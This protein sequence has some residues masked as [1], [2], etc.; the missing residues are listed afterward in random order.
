MS[1]RSFNVGENTISREMYRRNGNDSMG[2]LV[3]VEP[4]AN[5]Y[6]NLP[7][8]AQGV[9]AQFRLS[10][11]SPVWTWTHPEY[12]PQNKVRLEFTI[13]RF[14]GFEGLEGKRFT[15]TY[16]WPKNIADDRSKLGL[17]LRAF[18][19]RNFQAGEN[20]N[21]DDY[22]GTSFVTSATAELSADGQKIYSG[23]SREGIERRKTKLSPH[24]NA[25]GTEPVAVAAGAEKTGA[26]P[27][28]IPEDD[29]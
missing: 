13:Q 24:V 14:P 29:L 18:L 28:D 4:D 21:P 25:I 17:L 6:I 22:I 23:I 15:Q 9:K 11:I 10:G 7:L 5:E 26:D 2:E 16:P 1:D 19:G 12:G 8:D 20:V 3:L 27:F